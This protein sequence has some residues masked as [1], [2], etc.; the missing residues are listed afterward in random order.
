MT[1]YRLSDAPK[2]LDRPIQRCDN[3]KVIYFSKIILKPLSSSL[4]LVEILAIYGG[5]YTAMLF[6]VHVILSVTFCP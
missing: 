6:S 2:H 5:N 3:V 1:P 4:Q